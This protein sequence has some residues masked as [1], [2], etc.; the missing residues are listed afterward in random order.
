MIMTSPA[1]LTL[2][3]VSKVLWRLYPGRESFVL[4]LD[5]GGYGAY[6]VIDPRPVGPPWPTD[7]IAAAPTL[8]A[9]Y[10]DLLLQRQRTQA[11]R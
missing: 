7:R 4:R 11:R 2:R 6:V 5:E 3:T 8:A 9:L 1:R 10:R